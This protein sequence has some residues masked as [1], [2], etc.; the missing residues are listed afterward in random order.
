MNSLNRE[1]KNVLLALVRLGL[2]AVPESC[3]ESAAACSEKLHREWAEPPI[4]DEV[5]N[6]LRGLFNDGANPLS[7][8]NI[9]VG[10][11]GLSRKDARAAVDAF[12]DMAT[13]ERENNG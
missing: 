3:Y 2:E 9:L 13:S 8:Q 4:P 10:K 6:L 11:F 1:E 12:L 7:Y 5:W